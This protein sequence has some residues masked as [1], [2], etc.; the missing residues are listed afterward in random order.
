MARAE[1]VMA[2]TLGKSLDLTL[3]ALLSQRNTVG[4]GR[5]RIG[6]I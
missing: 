6:K 2:V 3:A 5:C 1:D 4:I